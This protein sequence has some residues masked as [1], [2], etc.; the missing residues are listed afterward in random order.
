LNDPRVVKKGTTPSN[1]PMLKRK[2][3]RRRKLV[4]VRAR[5]RARSGR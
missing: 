4:E 2:M 1:P 5:V 3:K